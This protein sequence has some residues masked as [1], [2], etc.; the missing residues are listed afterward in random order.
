MVSCVDESYS[1]LN[2]IEYSCSLSSSENWLIASFQK[3][4]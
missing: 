3:T 2:H 1:M 4:L